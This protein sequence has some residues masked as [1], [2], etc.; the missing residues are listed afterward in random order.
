MSKVI[1]ILIFLSFS[2]IARDSVIER[3]PK[4]GT[5]LTLLHSRL[6]QYISL[7]KEQ[8]QVTDLENGC[9]RLKK[10]LYRP[11][12]KTDY[13]RLCAVSKLIGE[14]KVFE[15]LKIFKNNHLLQS[16]TFIQE[17]KN[18]RPADLSS[19]LEVDFRIKGKS[20]FYSAKGLTEIILNYKKDDLGESFHLFFAPVNFRM[21]VFHTI[22]ENVLERIRYDVS[23]VFCQGVDWAEVREFH[24]NDLPLDVRYYDS[25]NPTDVTP[26]R[27]DEMLGAL[28]YR[29]VGQLGAS[30]QSTLVFAGDLPEIRF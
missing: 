15:D 4:T 9:L 10:E 21:D 11:I 1:F 20:G 24:R 25:E 30:I 17:G 28:Y 7:L 3:L 6:K 8:T 13:Y 29:A 5:T 19:L 12:R 2:V 26:R 27:F 23:C 16:F 22:E 18:I 14:D